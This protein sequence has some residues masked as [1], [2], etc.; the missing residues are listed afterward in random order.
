MKSRSPFQKR[1]PL[2]LTIEPEMDRNT[3]M[4][5][6]RG[7]ALEPGAGP[8]N[9]TGTPRPTAPMGSAFEAQQASGQTKEEFK[10]AN[11]NFGMTESQIRTQQAKDASDAAQIAAGGYM[12]DGTGPNQPDPYDDEFY[13]NYGANIASGTDTTNNALINSGD[14]IGN[15]VTTTSGERV[16]ETGVQSGLSNFLDDSGNTQ[17]IQE[18]VDQAGAGNQDN[19]YQGTGNVIFDEDLTVQDKV[20]KIQTTQVEAE[21]NDTTN[22]GLPPAVGNANVPASMGGKDQNA[23]S[24]SQPGCNDNYVGDGVLYDGM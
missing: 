10:A 1:S 17:E 12:A 6:G 11:P 22:Q 9:P 16:T 8:S 18:L 19:S 24:N 21:G 3:P 14:A 13:K 4:P 5:E 2:K 15:V 7:V 20:D 23:G